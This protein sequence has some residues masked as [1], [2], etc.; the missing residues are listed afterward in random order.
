MA[1]IFHDIGR[2]TVGVISHWQGYATGGVV[3]A[4]IGIVERL[5]GKQLG[6]RAYASIFLGLFLLVSF[7]LT[8]QDEYKRADDL[9]AKL[10]AKPIAPVAIQM[11]AIN[12]PPAQVMIQPP[13]PLP[14]LTKLKPEIGFEQSPI[15]AN[16]GLGKPEVVKNPGV[17]A[18]ITAKTDVPDIRL[19]AACDNPCT[20]ASYMAVDASALANA[21]LIAKSDSAY[22]IRFAIPSQLKEG[23]VVIIDFHSNDDRPIKLQYVRLDSASEK[24]RP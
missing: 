20:F 15:P 6:K 5:S 22:K 24:Y 17:R 10:D 13:T 16:E 3:T 11:P 19:E 23:K 8:W 7:F 1:G 4:I 2:F 18:L 9:Q 21:S 14:P 12:I